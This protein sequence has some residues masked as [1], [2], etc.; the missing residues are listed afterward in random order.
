MLVAESERSYIGLFGWVFWDRLPFCWWQPEAFLFVVSVWIWLMLYARN[1][2][3]LIFVWKVTGHTSCYVIFCT[4]PYLWTICHVWLKMGTAWRWTRLDAC[5]FEDGHCLKPVFVNNILV[6]V[7]AITWPMCIWWRTQLEVC[8]EDRH[9]LK[10]GTT[11]CVCGR[12]CTQL[13]DRHN[14]MFVCMD[15]HNLKYRHGF[16]PSC[17]RDHVLPHH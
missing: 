12:R 7:H 6:F 4:R 9:G 17:T 10:T 15:G 1:A 14:L 3:C 5:V 8:C 13:K 16:S 2:C 11:W